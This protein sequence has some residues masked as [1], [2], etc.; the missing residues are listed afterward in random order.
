DLR[1]I[2]LSLH[3][4]A[5]RRAIQRWTV[6]TQPVMERLV[7]LPVVVVAPLRWKAVG[8]HRP[9]S[10]AGQYDCGTVVNPWPE[11]E[12]GLAARVDAKGFDHRDILLADLHGVFDVGCD[13]RRR[14]VELTEVDWQ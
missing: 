9:Q 12:D 4:A 7:E 8:D 11:F 1:R 10:M 2:A 3:H 13:T 6:R 14:R 5:E